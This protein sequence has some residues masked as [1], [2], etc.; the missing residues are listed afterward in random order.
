MLSHPCWGGWTPAAAIG[1]DDQSC[2]FCFGSTGDG[3]IN[4]VRGQAVCRRCLPDPNR[5]E[6]EAG[7]EA[8]K[9]LEAMVEADQQLAREDW[10]L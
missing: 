6:G 8:D 4:V 5:D 7:R 2:A 10:L 3:W 1:G 9:R